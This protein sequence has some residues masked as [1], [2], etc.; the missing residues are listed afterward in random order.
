MYQN[1]TNVLSGTM[2]CKPT[3]INPRFALDKYN[4]S[5]DKDYHRI[6]MFGRNM[7][8]FEV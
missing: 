1:D 8:V 5:L 6:K 3:S 7:E 4:S 2:T